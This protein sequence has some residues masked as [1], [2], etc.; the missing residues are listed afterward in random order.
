MNDKK[1]GFCTLILLL[2]LSNL[3]SATDLTYDTM[4]PNCRE[5]ATQDFEGW[6]RCG[7][8]FILPN[9]HLDTLYSLVLN[10]FVTSIQDIGSSTIDLLFQKVGE[11]ASGAVNLDFATTTTAFWSFSVIFV[12]TPLAWFWGVLSSVL[13]YIL[14]MMFE[15]VKTYLLIAV[16]W[17]LW[18]TVI[19]REI[20]YLEK[21][22]DLYFMIGIVAIA[23]IGGSMLLLAYDV[24]VWRTLASAGGGGG[25]G[26][27]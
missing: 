2:L 8:T 9:L 20:K 10:A 6:M 4:F 12:T 19:F 21:L 24:N 3:A 16:S 13:V 11:F 15:F 1:K 7:A 17:M 18:S 25:G 22:T 5:D 23:L 27:G 14:L 26:A